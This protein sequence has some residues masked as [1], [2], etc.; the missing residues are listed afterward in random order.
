M[1][2]GQEIDDLPARVCP[3]QALACWL[4]VMWGR[5]QSFPI[6]V[7]TFT[8]EQLGSRSPNTTS[9][10]AWPLNVSSEIR[11]ESRGTTAEAHHQSGHA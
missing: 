3:R 10:T 5:E 2:R 11:S 1:D 7:V 8:A 6:S 4:P 9:S